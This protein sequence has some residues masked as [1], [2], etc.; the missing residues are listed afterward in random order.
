MKLTLPDCA[1]AYSDGICTYL[2]CFSERGEY[3][4]AL[5][6]EHVDVVVR[7]V[8]NPAEFA[9]RIGFEVLA[10]LAGGYAEAIEAMERLER[11]LS[12]I[13]T[14]AARP[15]QHGQDYDGETN[16]QVV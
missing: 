9:D 3:G 13:V 11:L 4:Y 2:L 15:E 5:C 6:L 1:A 8:W 7:P 10:A 12:S 14:G 16:P